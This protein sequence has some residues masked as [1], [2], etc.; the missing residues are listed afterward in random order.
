MYKII[1][2][3]PKIDMDQINEIEEFSS[4][5]ENE[6]DV[7][8][9]SQD[10]SEQK[11]FITITKAFSNFII[12]TDSYFDFFENVSQKSKIKIHL[13]LIYSF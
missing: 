1:T 3:K 5:L 13:L 7:N 6:E 8:P 11:V 9:D 2:M 10:S 4:D 12:N